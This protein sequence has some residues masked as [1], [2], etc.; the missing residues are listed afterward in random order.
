MA[1]VVNVVFKTNTDEVVEDTKKLN[2]QLDDAN[3]GVSEMAS[4]LDTMSKGGI[5]AM[6][7]VFKSVKT[8]AKGFRTLRGAIISTGIGALVVVVG[9][10]IEYFSNFRAGIKLVDTAM[11]GLGAVMGQLGAAA[12]ALINRDWSTFKNS[13][14]GIK[15]AVVVATDAVGNQYAA[16]DELYELRQRTIVQQAELEAQMKNQV[17]IVN[18]T[19]LSAEKRLAAVDE[20]GRIQREIIANS[21]NEI[22]LQREILTAQLAVENNENRRREITEEINTL[23]AEGIAKQSELNDIRYDT[24]QRRREIEKTEDEKRQARLDKQKEDDEKDAADKEK[25]D[26]EKAAKDLKTI[27]EK[28]A[29]ELEK[30]EALAVD[31]DE[32]DALELVKVDEKYQA[33][34]DKQIEYGGSTIELE[35]AR[36]AEKKR[37]E[38][39]QAARNQAAREEELAAEKK[40]ADDRKALDRSVANA[41]LD[42]AVGSMQLIGEIAGEGSRL[43]KAMAIGQ[44]TISGIQGVQNA[45]TTASMS[46]ITTAFPAY[47]FIQAGLAGG[48]ATAQLAAIARTPTG[49]GSSGGG[50]GGGG[51]IPTPSIGASSSIAVATGG[52]GNQIAGAINNKPARAYVVSGD[53]TT[54]QGLDRRIKTNATFG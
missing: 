37:I 6:Q 16:E 52:Q 51:G 10:L 30:R 18:D 4:G 25:K 44:A 2:T 9:S 26:A 53:V 36:D 7:G 31:Q 40:L 50:G 13:I 21:L 43:A 45:F 5:T 46:P 32:R 14:L 35:E 22:E 8:A 41:R 27:E 47:P 48:F 1:K 19:T 15:D 24:E 3:E 39:E 12:E 33:L 23:T 49:D 42:I 17:K 54:Q 11:A 28:A 20:V 38:E 29:F 34:I